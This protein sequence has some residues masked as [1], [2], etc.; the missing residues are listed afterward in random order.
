[1]PTTDEWIKKVCPTHVQMCMHTHTHTH[2]QGIYIYTGILFSH[3]KRQNS[4]FWGNVDRPWGRYAKLNNSER[5]I[6]C[7]LT[8]MWNWTNRNREE[9][10]SCQ[11]LRSGGNG[12]MLVREYKD[13]VLS[14]VS[15]EDLHY[16]MLTVV[17]NIILY[18]WK[19]L[20]RVWRYCSHNNNKMIITG[21]D[22]N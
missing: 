9:S 20:G 8:Y 3:K 14:W 17:E 22:V 5:Q 11:G 6:W 4:A 10:G 1:M 13:S 7:D 18:I 16:S 2:T 21:G 15:S 12:E 19:L